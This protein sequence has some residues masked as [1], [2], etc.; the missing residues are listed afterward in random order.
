MK[1][2]LKG[3]TFVL[4]VT[5]LGSIVV[6]S[7]SQ[8]KDG[9]SLE[10]LVEKTYSNVNISLTELSK[11]IEAS[12]QY[13]PPSNIVDGFFN[14]LPKPKNGV[15]V[16]VIKVDCF[17]N[18]EKIDITIR[19]SKGNE[20]IDKNYSISG[21]KKVEINNKPD[22]NPNENI[23]SL[24]KQVDEL[25]GA[26]KIT[27]KSKA[28]KLEAIAS[29]WE[30]EDINSIFFDGLP[31]SQNEIEVE[32]NGIAF[33]PFEGKITVEYKFSKNGDSIYRIYTIE[34]L[35]KVDE[36][37]SLYKIVNELYKNVT[38]TPTQKA[39]NLT[40][41]ESNWTIEKITSEWFNGLPQSKE[42][43]SVKVKSLD[44]IEKE[45][46]MFIQYEFSKDS[47]VLDRTYIVE[48]LK[49]Q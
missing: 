26:I 21:F 35:K 31:E 24:K 46:V 18:Q 37:N 43:V 7:C 38:I 22:N 12:E 13:W 19:Y 20:Y 15:S 33:K 8:Q 27:P 28:E 41:T 23:E 2:L 4:P 44:F 1:K 49:K 34:G 3:S 39:K 29:N 10:E 16:S 47:Q 6:T 40:A 17:P 45:G 5:L 36:E 11:Q 48:G 32:V 9:K 14:G 42:G 30:K 25:Y